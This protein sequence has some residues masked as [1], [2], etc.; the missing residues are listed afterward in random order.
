MIAGTE[1]RWTLPKGNEVTCQ[2]GA[3]NIVDCFVPGWADV[4][5]EG[6]W[7]TVKLK[8]KQNEVPSAT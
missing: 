8:E 6:Y 3:V 7:W 5:S 4:E 1:Y 2:C